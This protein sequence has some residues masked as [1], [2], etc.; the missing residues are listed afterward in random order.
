MALGRGP[1]PGP[2]SHPA[3]VPPGPGPPRPPVPPGP[4][5]SR[6]RAHTGGSRIRWG[7]RI[8][9][10]RL[11]IY[12]KYMYIYIYVLEEGPPQ[13]QCRIFLVFYIN[14]LL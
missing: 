13:G 3:Q 10:G 14:L 1:G 8:R 5:L 12:D 2:G 11:Y 9:L 4:G 6:P 7:P